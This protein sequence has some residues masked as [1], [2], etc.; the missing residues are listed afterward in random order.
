MISTD[1]IVVRESQLPIQPRTQNY[2][3]RISRRSPDCGGLECDR[4]SQGS[5]LLEQSALSTPS[6]ATTACRRRIC[7]IASLDPGSSNPTYCKRL[8]R[9]RH[10]SGCVDGTLDRA[11]R[12]SLAPC[13][14]WAMPIASPCTSG[15]RRSES[16]RVSLPEEWQLGAARGPLRSRSCWSRRQQ[17][18]QPRGVAQSSGPGRGTRSTGIGARDRVPS[19]SSRPR[20]EGCRSTDCSFCLA[21]SQQGANSCSESTPSHKHR[22]GVGRLP[23][24]MVYLASPYSHPDPLV[25]AT[26]FDAAC[27]ATAKL[28]RTGR[29]VF[30]PIVHGHPLVRFGLPTDWKFWQRFDAEHLR[31]C[32][33][34]L[35]LQIDGWRESEGVRAEI[36]LAT[37]MGKHVSY[38]EATQ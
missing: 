34:V 25:R 7:R 26:R 22:C 19:E 4:R 31:R 21:P 20:M 28:I 8:V 35:V 18:H 27:R 10:P 33:E 15:P 1:R 30:S 37:A 6:H 3:I 17:H 11:W 29:A 9:S 2:G 13:N 12:G 38:R 23:T 32:D 5:T 16:R 36:E 14:C 24:E